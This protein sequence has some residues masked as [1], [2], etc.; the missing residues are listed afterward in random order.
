MLSENEMSV[1][2]YTCP[3]KGD[4]IT[5]AMLARRLGVKKRDICP[6]IDRGLDTKTIAAL[7]K[8]R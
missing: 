8:V 2:L 7:V 4:L 3:I 6:L 5:L 1:T